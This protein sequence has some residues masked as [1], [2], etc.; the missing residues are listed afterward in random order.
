MSRFI[1]SLLIFFLALTPVLFLADF[2]YSKAIST[3]NGS[4]M[5][6]WRDIIEGQ[7]SA[8]IIVSGDSRV[9]ADFSPEVIDSLTGHSVYDIGVIGQHHGIQRIRYDLYRKYNDMPVMLIQTV[10]N[11]LLMKKVTETDRIQFLP[12]MWN[13][14]YYRLAI[15]SEPRFFLI[16]SIPWFRYHSYHFTTMKKANPIPMTR[17]G[18]DLT[19]R[20]GNFND[21]ISQSFFCDEK[22]ASSFRSY[23]SGA[24][25]EGIK[26]LLVIPPFS[27]DMRF[28][29]GEK[30]K[31]LD[32]FHSFA[33]E[34][35]VP[36]LD[37][38]QMFSRDSSMFSD[39]THL[40]FDGARAFSDSLAHDILRLGLLPD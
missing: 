3:L 31:M 37:Y 13:K 21:Q 24:M 16:R 11:W 40:N 4:N 12:W 20:V 34:M 6:I 27:E 7:A 39:M 18:F 23:I 28:V 38:N 19:K 1:R 14:D 10:D 22:K 2:M 5:E 26:V 35:Q 36:L 30:Q 9:N 33:S 8:D 15:K 17:R 29:P 25:S 32:Y